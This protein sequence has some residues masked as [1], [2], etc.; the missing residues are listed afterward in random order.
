M[1]KSTQNPVKAGLVTHAKEWIFGGL[2]HY[3]HNVVHILTTFSDLLDKIFTEAEN[4]PLS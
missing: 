3:L 1:I 2:Y 4:C